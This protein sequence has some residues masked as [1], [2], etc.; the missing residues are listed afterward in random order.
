MTK[1]P[2]S[3]LLLKRIKMDFETHNYDS[4]VT[5]SR[6]LIEEVLIHVIEDRTGQNFKYN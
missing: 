6:T 1:T 3:I 4:V 2:H 5:K